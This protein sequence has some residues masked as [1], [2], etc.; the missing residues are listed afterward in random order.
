MKQDNTLLNLAALDLLSDG[1]VGTGMGVVWLVVLFGSGLGIIWLF[2]YRLPKYLW[3]RYSGPLGRAYYRAL[4][5]SPKTVE[6]IK[7]RCAARD[8]RK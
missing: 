2:Y 6:R 7:N 8:P 1:A 5:I 4:G 3:D